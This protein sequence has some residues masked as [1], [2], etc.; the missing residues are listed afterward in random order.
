MLVA[1]PR[2]SILGRLLTFF[3][4]PPSCSNGCR[5]SRVRTMHRPCYRVQEVPQPL[6][7]MRWIEPLKPLPWGWLL[8]AHRTR[9]LPGGR[10]DWFRSLFWKEEMELTLVGLQNSGKTTFVNVIAVRQREGGCS[11]PLRAVP[12]RCCAGPRHNE[13]W[14]PSCRGVMLTPLLRTLR[15]GRA[16]STEQSGQ[17]SEDMIPTVGFNMRKVSKGNVTIKV[18]G[19]AW[20]TR[21]HQRF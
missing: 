17:F 6:P 8:P 12:G 21:P 16:L 5:R 7:G 3:S 10:V 13:L 18:R 4:I 2:V 20:K 14:E 9:A 1:Q 15:L 11:K 19:H